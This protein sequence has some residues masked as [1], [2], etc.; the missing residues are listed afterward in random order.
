MVTVTAGR[1]PLGRS[2]RWLM[3]VGALFAVTLFGGASCADRPL[4]PGSMAGYG[5]CPN[6]LLQASLPGA[7][8][9]GGGAPDRG[10]GPGET[11]ISACLFVVVALAGLAL[12]GAVR[13]PL[14]ADVAFWWARSRT[15]RV[16][17][18]AVVPMWVDALRI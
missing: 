18:L 14:L 2:L 12:A 7:L 1:A 13:R 15:A 11:G 10:H 9:A 6:V 8:E 3:V 5:A 16:R 4:V 17:P